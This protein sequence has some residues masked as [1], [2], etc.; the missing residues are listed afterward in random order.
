MGIGLGRLSNGRLTRVGVLQRQSYKQVYLLPFL[1]S[2]NIGKISVKVGLKNNY[3]S[4]I[5]S[6]CNNRII[7]FNN[8]FS[9]IC[10]QQRAKKTVPA[11]FF[12]PNIFGIIYFQLFSCK[13]HFQSSSSH[14]NKT[15]ITHCYEK[16]GHGFVQ[17]SVR[18]VCSKFKVDPLRCYNTGLRQ[19]FT[20]QKLLNCEILLTM[21][22]AISNS[23]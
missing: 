5:L 13:I 21:K 19:A 10:S 9:W 15:R 17:Q 6:S 18:N 4:Y 1:R 11:I 23:L 7:V 12:F 20:I 3:F 22:T 2:P 14:C 8:F 16:H